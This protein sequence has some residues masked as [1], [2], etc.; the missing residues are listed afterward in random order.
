MH[1]ITG[2]TR[3]ELEIRRLHVAEIDKATNNEGQPSNGRTVIVKSYFKGKITL[4]S[5]KLFFI[6]N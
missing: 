1:A 4:Q 2:H 3:F 5:F 6:T